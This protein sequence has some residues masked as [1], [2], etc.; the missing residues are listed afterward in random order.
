MRKKIFL[1]IIV[2]LLIT[3]ALA[4]GQRPLEVEYPLTP[5]G[6]APFG[7]ETT[8]FALYVKYIY[9][10][11]FAL[12]GVIAFAAL[13]YAG[14]LYMSSAGDPNKIKDARSRIFSALLGMGILLISYILLIAIN[15]ETI[16]LITPRLEQI[17]SSDYIPSLRELRSQQLGTVK[18]IGV[19]G[20]L[21]MEGI[22][23]LGDDIFESS[24]LCNCFNARGLSLCNG[25][26]EGSLCQPQTCYA[27]E[28]A[29]GHPCSN[30]DEIKEWQH[31][32]VFWFD[33][34][35]YYQNR[36]TGTN[37]IAA[38]NLEG[39]G[40]ETIRNIIGNIMA[41]NFDDI[42]DNALNYAIAGYFGGEAKVLQQEVNNVSVPTIQY[43]ENYIATLSA[44]SDPRT[45]EALN[46]LLDKEEQKRDLKEDLVKELIKFGFLVEAMKT[47]INQLAHLTEQC[48]LRTQKECSAQSYGSCHD[49]FL[50]CQTLCIGLNPCPVI[51]IAIAGGEFE[52]LRGPIE[53]STKNISDLVDQIRQLR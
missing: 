13:I 45:R 48:A 8:T 20:N 17:P 10:I 16:M 11:S 27:S 6:E 44:D 51:D 31:L 39:A 1:L 23:E 2:I 50:G 34:L 22:E 32:M 38:A 12:A 40:D 42:L 28:D 7:V 21:A 35:V 19:M 49:T 3:P 14:L 47:P 29:D 18:E 9:N 26:S 52:L 5:G 37:L 25:G 46:E 41:G 33:E 4:L 15:P 24:L 43:Y 30:Y 53:D 36:A